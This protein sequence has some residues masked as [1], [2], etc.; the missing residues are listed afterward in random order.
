MVRHLFVPY[1]MHGHVNPMVP[2]VAELVRR[3]D[4][5]LVAVPAPYADGFREVG[6]EVTEIEATV[7]T[8]FPAVPTKED[9]ARMR[10]AG[11]SMIR[12]RPRIARELRRH[13]PVWKPDVVV[14][15]LAARWGAMA[16]RREG[17]PLASFSVTYTASE[18]M[19]VD[20]L[21][22]RR[23]ARYVRNLRRLGLL[24]QFHPALRDR[25]G[26]ALVNAMDEMQPR[27]ETFGERYHFV[28]P[29][30]RD[31]TTYGD[32]DLPWGR[33]RTGPTLFVSPGTVFA[34]APGFFRR[35]ADGFAGTEWTVVMATATFDPDELGPLPENVVARRF[36][37]QTP[38]LA[39]SSVFVTRA[40][41]NS[42]MEALL[43]EVPMIAVP[44]AYDQKG[45]AAR[46]RQ[47]GVAR[48]LPETSDGAA[49]LAAARELVADESVRSAVR[50]LAEPIRN[51]NPAAAAADALQHFALRR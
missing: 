15:D 21:R 49:F 14:A 19:V 30:L 13:W 10:R 3:G 28:G 6:G 22:A 46:L 31:T 11:L 44:R 34:C 4:Q 9:R 48:D 45:V 26:L 41:M 40:S 5:V 51:L 24:K 1:P 25:A 37:P 35:V 17:T 8:T 39:H 20:G 27:R 50:R 12:Q 33:I 32:S 43:R 38:L 29:L 2:L 42:A 16:A 23:S 47:M 36:V 18:Q 7:P